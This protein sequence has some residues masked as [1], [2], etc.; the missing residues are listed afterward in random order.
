M[1]R[2]VGGAL[3]STIKL[4]KNSLVPVYRQLEDKLRGLILSGELVNGLR[5]PSTRQFSKDLGVSRLT[6]KN[7]Y[8]QLSA[9]KF[10]NSHP[11]AGTFVAEI[12]LNEKPPVGKPLH[13]GKSAQQ[14]S[15]RAVQLSKS[16]AIVRLGEHRPFRPGVPALDRFPRKIW[17]SKYS[18]I[19]RESSDSTF[20]YGQSGGAD[21][22]KRAIAGHVND[23]RGMQIDPEQVIITAG[24][25][26]AFSLIAFTLLNP[27][28]EVWIED[29][30]HIAGRDA[31]R[32]FGAKALPVRVDAE[33][34]DLSYAISK[35]AQ[36]RL[37]FVT[38]SHQHPLGVTMS[39]QRRIQLLEFARK[40]QTWIIED[41]YDS[42]FRYRDRPL[43]AMQSLDNYGQ[44]LYVGSFSKTLFPALRLGYL[45]SPPEFVDS[46]SVG[47]T[48]LSQNVST[49]LQEIVSSFIEDG[50]YNA[51]IRKMRELY[52]TRLDILYQSLEKEA[53]D[54]IEFSKPDAGMHL[55][56]WLRN[57]SLSDIEV[58]ESIWNAGVDCLPLSIFSQKPLNRGGVIMGFACAPEQKIP[59][60][61]R[62]LADSMRKHMTNKNGL[63]PYKD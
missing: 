57:A 16:K 26:Q 48:L 45:I 60:L 17:G 59:E 37:I 62:I 22:L 35:Y 20:S 63:K 28:D 34:F 6:V 56:G 12:A 54:L 31:V 43:R 32:A 49:I 24:A 23:H 25:Q 46:F 14:L 7:V 11:G 42:E 15:E 4:E 51:H 41:D 9:E 8:E 33:G 2:Q 36:A 10:L 53:D 19:L 40:N 30:G 58:C 61:T 52:S 21:R 39:L 44:V 55:I 3:L 1:N 5:L 27:G 50:S 13:L 38:P 47:Q 29:P 18:K